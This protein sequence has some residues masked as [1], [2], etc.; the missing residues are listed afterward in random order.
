MTELRSYY[1]GA[2]SLI[3]AKIIKW[4]ETEI[5]TINEEWYLGHLECKIFFKREE[6]AIAFKLKFGHLFY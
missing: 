1:Y 6:M 2:G 4:L 5:G 3:G